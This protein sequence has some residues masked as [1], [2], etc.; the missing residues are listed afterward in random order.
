[1]TASQVA[2]RRKKLRRLFDASTYT[3][4]ANAHIQPVHVYISSA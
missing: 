4:L 3:T 2:D 1:M